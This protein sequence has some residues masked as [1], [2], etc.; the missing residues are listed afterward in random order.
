MTANEIGVEVDF[1]VETEAVIRRKLAIGAAV[2]DTHALQNFEIAAGSVELNQADFVDG[3]NKTDGTAVHD[4]NFGAVDLDEGVVYAETA[5]GCEQVLDR[6]HGGAIAVAEHGTERYARD[7]A[8]IGRD[9]GAFGIAVGDEEAQASFAISRIKN[10][11]D[12]RSAMNPRTRYGDFTGKCGLPRPN[13]SL[14]GPQAV[15]SVFPS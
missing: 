13:K 8:L 9:L 11:G 15:L 12:W 14:H 7:V 1:D 5:E 4:G 6:R 2:L 3:L 10:D